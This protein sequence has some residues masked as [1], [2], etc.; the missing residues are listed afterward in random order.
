MP[1][2]RVAHKTPA[3]GSEFTR[4]Y[5]GKIHKMTVVK[6]SEGIAYKVENGT[7]NTPSAAAKSV[8]KSA[9]NGWFFWGIEKR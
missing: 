1:K 7:Y 4:K 9:I 8:T 6:R 2:K 5:K 3:V